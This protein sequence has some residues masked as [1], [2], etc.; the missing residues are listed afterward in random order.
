MKKIFTFITLAFL[1]LW[2]ANVYAAWTITATVDKEGRIKDHH[3]QYE[4]VYRIKLACTSDAS[5]TDYVMP[6]NIMGKIRNSWLYMIKTVPGTG[7]DAPTAAFDLDIEDDN[8]DHLLDT[9]ANPNGS[10]KFTPGHA[11]LG[12]F[13]IV[14]DHLSVVIATLG[15]ANTATIYLYFAK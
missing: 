14:F 8:D 15:N 2:G 4:Y 12:I 13:P 10:N 7:G 3:M 5:G 6:S 1:L 9:D 11:T